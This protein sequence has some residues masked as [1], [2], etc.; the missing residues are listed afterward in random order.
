MSLVVCVSP[1]NF[2][3]TI[4]LVFLF[5]FVINRLLRS[6]LLGAAVPGMT[7]ITGVTNQE[8]KNTPV[9]T[10]LVVKGV[11]RSRIGHDHENHHHRID[12][13]QL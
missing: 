10:Y 9:D 8:E 11:E 12:P 4:K 7:V 6:F 1:H 5:L 3:R 13:G 2:L